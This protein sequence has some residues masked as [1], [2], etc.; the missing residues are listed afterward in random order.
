MSLRKQ[1]QGGESREKRSSATPI[2]PGHGPTASQLHTPAAQNR[3]SPSRLEACLAPGTKVRIPLLQLLDPWRWLRSRLNRPF[4]RQAVGGA[5][6]LHRAN[7]DEFLNR[8]HDDDDDSPLRKAA[9]LCIFICAFCSP[10]LRRL[11]NA[12]GRADKPRA[13]LSA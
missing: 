3:F 5:E 10:F 11:C 7:K 13:E 4:S 1:P 12:I 6:D 9:P 2:K 8:R